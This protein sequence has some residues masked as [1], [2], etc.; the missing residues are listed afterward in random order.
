MASE[1]KNAGYVAKG[2]NISG[3]GKHV[4]AQIKK[5]GQR[6]SQ[7]VAAAQRTRFTGPSFNVT[8]RGG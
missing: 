2:Y 4:Q 7:N 3:K 5:S 6:N 1:A 8:K